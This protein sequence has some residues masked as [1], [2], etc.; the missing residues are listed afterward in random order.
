MTELFSALIKIDKIKIKMPPAVPAGIAT[1]FNVLIPIF[2]T[3]TLTSVA[4]IMFKM[5][6]GAHINEWIYQIVQAPL[7]AIF[8]SPAGIIAIVVISQLFWFLG[9]HGGLVISPIPQSVDG[10]RHRG[11]RGGCGRGTGGDPAR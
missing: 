11:Q 6:S 3:L 1:S 5:V 10:G 9:I 7:E 8:Q 4:G 2:I